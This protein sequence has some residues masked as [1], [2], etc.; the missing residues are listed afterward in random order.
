MQYFDF[1][2]DRETTRCFILMSNSYYKKPLNM[3]YA[4]VNF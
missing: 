1:Y 2:V 4:S 3:T